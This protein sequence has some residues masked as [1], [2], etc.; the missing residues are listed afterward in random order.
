MVTLRAELGE[1][2]L[3]A[4]LLAFRGL[5]YLLPLGVAGLVYLWLESRRVRLPR[6]GD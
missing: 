1:P 2:A 6:A 4:A 3:V 5:Y